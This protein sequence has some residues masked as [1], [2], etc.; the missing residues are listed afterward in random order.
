MAPVVAI[1]V[2]AVLLGGAIGATPAVREHAIGPIRTFALSAVLAVL[3]LHLVP[4][5]L[6]G[7]GLAG[8]L[9][10]GAGVAIPSV[11]ERLP[12]GSAGPRWSAD[13]V[14]LGLTAHQIGDGLA[15]WSASGGREPTINLSV[16]LASHAT[17]IAAL[18]YLRFEALCG[19]ASAWLRVIV[20][21][22]ASGAAIGF[23]QWAHAL[24]PETWVPWASALASGFLFHVVLED[25]TTDPPLSAVERSIDLAAATLGIALAILGLA[26]H[27]EVDP[28]GR[29][30][31][32]AIGS[33]LL[34]LSIQTAPMLLLGLGLGGALRTLGMRI[35]ARYIHGGGPISQSLRGVAIGVPLPLCA[36]GVL[37]VAQ[38]LASR[39]AGAALVVAFLLSTPELGIE[40]LALTA[41]FMSWP[42]ALLRLFAASALPMTAALAVAQGSGA[43][44]RAG[45]TELVAEDLSGPFRRRLVHSFD[46]LL[47]H[48]GPWITAGV[49]AAAYVEVVVPAGALRTSPRWLDIAFMSILALPS[50]VCAS[51]ATPLGAVLLQKGLSPGAVLAGLILGPATNVATIVFLTRTYGRGAAWFGLLA[52]VGATAALA[53][54]LNAHNPDW[55][56]AVE[57]AS[58]SA[59]FQPAGIGAAVLLAIILVRSMWR[60]GLRGWLASLGSTKDVHA[61]VHAVDPKERAH[62]H[63][64]G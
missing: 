11:I 20:L 51:S 4:E 58:S 31:H 15:V 36:C 54:G 19:R 48:I 42:F 3:A 17:P 64:H 10:F 12:K 25:L 35:P 8:L 61:H 44:G 60:T 21:A 1:F 46:D 29:E 52:M 26:A 38:S 27:A 7:L 41:S 2:L 24:A 9:V 22:A 56:T 16:A 30:L 55:A 32:R 45:G 57:L 59:R 34:D 5:M 49:L 62:A 53:L 23:G 63:E 47:H 50:Y 33:A 40:T 39:G 14:F 37:P 28:D 43:R 18:V 13:L 6:A